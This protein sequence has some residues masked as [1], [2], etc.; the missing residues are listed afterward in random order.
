VSNV[1][2]A[3][4]AYNSLTPLPIN[5]THPVYAT[6]NSTTVADDACSPL[7]ASTPDLANYVVLIRRGTCTF[8][9]KLGNAAAKGAKYFLIYNNVAGL[10][11][12]STGNYTAALISA[13]DGA[14][15]VGQIAAGNHPALTFP[16]SGGTINIPN[17]TG[18]QVSTFSTYGPTFDMYFKPAVAARKCSLLQL[19]SGERLTNRCSRW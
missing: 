2:H 11:A 13:E 5:G 3:P 9:T 7:P 14:Y 19:V 12:I 18:G 15:L 16:Q 4:I 1:S 17:P 6:S 8:A 10:S